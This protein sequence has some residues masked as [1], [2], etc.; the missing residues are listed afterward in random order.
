MAMLLSAG[1]AGI[2]HLKLSKM[3]FDAPS[4]IALLFFAWQ[5]GC[6]SPNV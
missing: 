6:R 1:G 2:W 4:Y 3:V 5:P